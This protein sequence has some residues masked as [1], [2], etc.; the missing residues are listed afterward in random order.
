M[1]PLNNDAVSTVL[2]A[3]RE[4]LAM[5]VA[6]LF[7]AADEATEWESRHYGAVC[8]VKDLAVQRCLVVLVDLD[9]KS[10]VFS[11]EITKGTTYTISSPELS[12]VPWRDLCCRAAV[13]RRT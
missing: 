6:R 1:T 13:R 5:T 3:A 10:E 7:F 8:L 4:P 12:L 2:G 9:S 11:Q